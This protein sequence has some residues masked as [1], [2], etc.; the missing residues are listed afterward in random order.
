MVNTVPFFFFFFKFSLSFYKTPVRPIVENRKKRGLTEGNYRYMKIPFTNFELQRYT[1][2]Y[3]DEHYNLFLFLEK[4]E[5]NIALAFSD[6]HSHDGNYV[7]CL[8]VTFFL[9]I[10]LKSCFFA[11]I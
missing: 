11:Q 7:F 9:A 4:S 2:I 10:W 6:P 5:E 1:I 8:K 3:L